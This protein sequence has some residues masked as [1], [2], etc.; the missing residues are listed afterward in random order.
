MAQ[1][2]YTISFLMVGAYQALGRVREVMDLGVLRTLGV[3][4]WMKDW[5][6]V[7]GV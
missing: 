5:R 4:S 6:A 3:G 1:L 2:S 7:G